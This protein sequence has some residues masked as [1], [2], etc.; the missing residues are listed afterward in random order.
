[1]GSIQGF[2]SARTTILRKTVFLVNP[3]VLFSVHFRFAS[4]AIQQRPH[5]GRQRSA[6]IGE[7]SAPGIFENQSFGMQRLPGNAYFD[8]QLGCFP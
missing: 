3:F 5:V 7:R 8:R 2:V 6:N 4:Q 1:V